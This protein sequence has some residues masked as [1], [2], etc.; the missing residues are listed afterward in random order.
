MSFCVLT[1][2]ID[3]HSSVFMLYV[4]VFCGFCLCH[5]F[6]FFCLYVFNILFNAVNL[7]ANLNLTHLHKKSSLAKLSLAYA[8]SM[9]MFFVVFQLLGTFVSSVSVQLN[10]ILSKC[11]VKCTTL[12][13]EGLPGSDVLYF[14][15]DHW[16]SW[17]QAGKDSLVSSEYTHN[18]NKNLFLPFGKLILWAVHQRATFM[19]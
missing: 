16:F 7:F 18:V 17:Q 15:W 5:M 4:F 2:Y 9:L 1:M 12:F 11:C 8:N 6:V 19:G 13:C 14:G 3:V 10:C